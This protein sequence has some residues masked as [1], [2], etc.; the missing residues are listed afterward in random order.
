MAK[1]LDL[2][3]CIFPFEPALYEPAGLKSVF[4]GHPLIDAL[5]AERAEA[6]VTRARS[7]SACSR[8]AAS[9]R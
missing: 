4:V 7:S 6:P 8:A 1:L 5:A 3:I 2:M 9:A